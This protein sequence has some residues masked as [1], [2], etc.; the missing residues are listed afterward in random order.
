MMSL[1][2]QLL[3]TSPKMM[4]GML[5]HSG[6]GAMVAIMAWLSMIAVCG[7]IVCVAEAIKVI[8]QKAGLTIQVHYIVSPQYVVSN[9][10]PFIVV[11]ASCWDWPACGLDLGPLIM[12]AGVIV[13]YGPGK[14]PL[15]LVFRFY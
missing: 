8:D 3:L 7:S 12:S 5:Y 9:S 13:F 15:E 10:A 1:A 14:H 2:L 11:P 6:L 4:K